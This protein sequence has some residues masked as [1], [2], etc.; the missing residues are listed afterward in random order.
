MCRYKYAIDRNGKVVDTSA[1]NKT[2]S[3]ADLAEK[4]NGKVQTAAGVSVKITE[5]FNSQNGENFPLSQLGTYSDDSHVA[6]DPN[7]IYLDTR[8]GQVY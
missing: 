2:I 1:K 7:K 5:D 3:L 4:F 6:I 8:T